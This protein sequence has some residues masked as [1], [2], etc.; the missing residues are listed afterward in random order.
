MRDNF[1]IFV[2]K[3]KVHLDL[4]MEKYMLDNF[5]KTNL[6]EKDNII[7]KMEIIIKEILWMAS[8]M[9]MELWKIITKLNM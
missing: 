7:G 2:N 3:V 9:V 5:I 8:D 1:I 6:M 4:K